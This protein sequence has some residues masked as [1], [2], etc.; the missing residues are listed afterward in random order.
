M[1]KALLTL[2]VLGGLLLGALPAHAASLS[3]TDPEGDAALLVEPSEPSLDLIKS[4]LSTDATK[5]RWNATLKQAAS[6][7]PPVSVGYFFVFE[8]GYN[9][10][11]YDLR[12]REDVVGSTIALRAVETGAMDLP[13]KD[14][15]YKFDRKTSVVSIEVP[16]A[17]LAESIKGHD[18][19]APPFRKGVKLDAPLVGAYRSFG[20]VF[21]RFDDAPAPEGA[22]FTV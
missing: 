1:R 18:A 11:N 12:V 21:E 15:K 7:N 4:S 16:I 5:L 13:C 3:W 9:A 20:A 8:F 17:S 2:T 6:G 19:A 14:C 10:I 22:E